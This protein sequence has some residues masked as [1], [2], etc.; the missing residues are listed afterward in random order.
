MMTREEHDKRMATLQLVTLPYLIAVTI[1]LEARGEPREGKIA[2]AYVCLDRMSNGIAT[3]DILFPKQ[4]SSFTYPSATFESLRKIDPLDPVF[5][6][7]VNIAFGV[8]KGDLENP[9]PGIKYFWNPE[10]MRNE[11]GNDNPYWA[12]N[13]IIVGQVG[14]HRFAKDKV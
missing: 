5:V 2:V 7:C 8:V 1:W 14:K 3:D 9:Y 12:K 13:T 4:F 11:T 6:E 10:T